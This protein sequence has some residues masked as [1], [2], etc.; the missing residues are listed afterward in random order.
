MKLL[1]FSRLGRR[2]TH[3]IAQAVR[4]G[5]GITERSW[6]LPG[7]T[8]GGSTE[9]VAQIIAWAH[10]TM[11]TMRR[12]YGIDHVAFALACRDRG[13]RVVCSSALGVMRP[14]VFYT[15]EGEERIAAFIADVRF[16]S[17]GDDAEIVGAL[18]SLGDVA[19][20]LG[21]NRAA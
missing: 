6:P 1:N 11:G 5:V 7:R 20:E 8:E 13:G 21:M 9:L 4:D 2:P 17:P 3:R 18:L 15:S 12:P 16:A 19:Y 14:S 10:E